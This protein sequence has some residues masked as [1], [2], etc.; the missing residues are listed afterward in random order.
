MSEKH[1]WSVWVAVCVGFF[2]VPS[3]AGWPTR[4]DEPKG[5]KVVLEMS[6]FVVPIKVVSVSPQVGG[7]VVQLNIEEGQR[8]KKGDVL[9][10]LEDT[11]YKA[12]VESAKAEVDI[13][14]AEL[15]KIQL[16]GQGFDLTIGRAKVRRAKAKVEIAQWHLEKTVI[17]APV[18]GTILAKKTEEGNTISPLA[19]N[20]ALAS[21]VCEM[22]DLRELEVEVIVQEKDIGIVTKGQGCIIALDAFPKTTYKGRVSRLMPVADRARGA[23]PVRVKIDVPEKDTN[24]RP[25]MRAIVKFLGAQR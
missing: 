3:L 20:S 19:S 22:A 13:A 8:V 18:A 15:N 24:L 21:T 11:V 5:N 7:Q 10:R 16:G 12:R 6:G 2:L 4:G 1:V 9:A 14:T 23:L 17:R 25:E